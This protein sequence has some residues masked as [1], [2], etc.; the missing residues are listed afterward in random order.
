[1]NIG[2]KFHSDINDDIEVTVIDTHYC[3]EKGN[4]EE[5]LLICV[6]EGML[7]KYLEIT[8]YRFGEQ[9][10]EKPQYIG[11]ICAIE[12]LKDYE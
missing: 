12:S 2:D 1:M 8:S 9:I 4:W 5:T 11:V 6:G 7:L 10:I 3:G